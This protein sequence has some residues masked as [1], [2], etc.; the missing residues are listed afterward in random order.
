MN[1]QRD[2][3]INKVVSIFLIIIVLIIIFFVLWQKLTFEPRSKESPISAIE[4][5]QQEKEEEK[6]KQ[7]AEEKENNQEQEKDQ[8]EQANDIKCTNINKIEGLAKSTNP[9]LR[10]MDQY[11]TACNSF[12]FDKHKLFTQMMS[13]QQSA[14]NMAKE[15]A[16]TLKEFSKFGVTPIVIVEPVNEQEMIDTGKFIAGDYDSWLNDY[17][18]AL[19]NQGISD[20]QM[21]IWLPFP[22]ANTPAYFVKSQDFS[23]AVNRY[24]SIL[25]QYFPQ[26]RGSISLDATT[27]Q[28][29]DLDWSNGQY[30]SLLPYVSGIQKGL[31]DSFCLQ[32]FPW[33]PPANSNDDAIDNPELF[34]NS[35]LAAEAADALGIKKIWFNTGTFSSKYT[36]AQ[37]RIEITADQREKILDGIVKEAVEL[38]NKGYSVWINLF[39]EDKSETTE[40]TNWSYWSDL[41][42]E[43]NV[44]RA[45]FIDFASKVYKLGIGLSLFDTE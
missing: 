25:K 6:S 35:D 30:I 24:L 12:V 34:L 14:E 39:T 23:L 45:V 16:V 27:Y 9:Y 37:K 2:N 15:I 32:G 10:K 7:A 1:K 38:K 41:A 13:T 18:S 29:D 44:H 31:V 19:K 17:F 3:L 20:K 5:N 36:Q 21:G 22:E 11:Q 4:H 43:D 26:A 33:S 8:P 40:E 42:E 28:S